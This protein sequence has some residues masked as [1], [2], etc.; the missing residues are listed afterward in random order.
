MRFDKFRVIMDNIDDFLFFERHKKGVDDLTEEIEDIQAEILSCEK[1]FH[2]REDTHYD[3]DF[4]RNR[5]YVDKITTELNRFG[6]NI[7]EGKKQNNLNL[8]ARI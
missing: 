8:Q 4:M 3:L 2:D 1:E 7:K 5:E 6:N